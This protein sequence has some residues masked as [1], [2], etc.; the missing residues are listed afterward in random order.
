MSSRVYL[1]ECIEQIVAFLNTTIQQYTTIGASIATCTSP[2]KKGSPRKKF[3]NSY[4]S[5]TSGTN[6]KI[7]L[8]MYTKWG[9]LIGYLVELLTLRGGSLTDTLVLSTTRVALG[10]FFLENLTTSA[11]ISSSGNQSNNEIQLNALK[12]TTTI[13]SQYQGHRGVIL[14]E[15]LHSIARLPTNKRSKF[16]KNN[17][18]SFLLMNNINRSCDLQS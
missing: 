7:L 13:F 9:E 4:I 10:A 3:N 8:K 1:E 5:P 11:A 6:K 17:L 12:L 16:L 15:L 14:E 2:S 18:K